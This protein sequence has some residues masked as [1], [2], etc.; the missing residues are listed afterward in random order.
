MNE[1]NGSPE[2][3]PMPF[4]DRCNAIRAAIKQEAQCVLSLRRLITVNQPTPMAD[5][6]LLQIASDP[7]EMAANLT[8]AYRHMEDAAMRVGKAIQAWDGGVSCYDRQTQPVLTEGPTDWKQ[9]VIAEKAELDSK[10]SK[11]LT[12]VGTPSFQ[13]LDFESQKLLEHQAGSMGTYSQILAERIAKFSTPGSPALTATDFVGTMPQPAPPP[14]DNAH[15]APG[16]EQFA[17]EQPTQK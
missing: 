4:N 5:R 6:P 9:R 12:F 3:Q 11:L 7:G 16:C 10:L 8:L 1:S 15:V 17:S 14:V 13:A 2:A